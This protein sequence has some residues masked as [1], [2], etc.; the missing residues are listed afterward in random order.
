MGLALSS[1]HDA[2]VVSTVQA[3]PSLVRGL[4]EAARLITDEGVAASLEG[5]A[6][7]LVCLEEA[8]RWT[9]ASIP[10]DE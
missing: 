5:A 6:V 9:L 2:H 7:R 10:L 8:C 3:V 1:M 4:V